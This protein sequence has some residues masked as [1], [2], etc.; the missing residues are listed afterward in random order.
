MSHCDCR[1][2]LGA[3]VHGADG[4]EE[5]REGRIVIRGAGVD[6]AVFAQSRNAESRLITCN[7]AGPLGDVVGR[8]GH[9]EVAG[10]ELE[11]AHVVEVDMLVEDVVTVAGVV[12]VHGELASRERGVVAGL[13]AAY[14]TMVPVVQGVDG[15]V[16]VAEHG[17]LGVDDAA[18]GAP[19]ARPPQR[20]G[21]LG[22]LDG[23][24]V[25]QLKVALTVAPA[26]SV[27]VGVAV[28][29]D[30]NAGPH[31]ATFIGN[32][33]IFNNKFSIR[34]NNDTSITWN[35]NPTIFNCKRAAP[36]NY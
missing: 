25:F 26:D 4:G 10:A 34:L 31:H 2:R 1:W 36:F 35:V 9:G 22:V 23:R 29:P 5:S 30:L 16:V 11:A 18:R 24:T 17:I 6:V 8:G 21:A 28:A 27:L 7:A 33:C 19:V 20:Q 14:G 12:P 15:A 13:L 3:D 32:N